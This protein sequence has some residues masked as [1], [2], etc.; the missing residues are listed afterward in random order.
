MKKEFVGVLVGAL[1]L[2]GCLLQTSD[3]PGGNEPPDDGITLVEGF[4]YESITDFENAWWI[5][6]SSDGATYQTELVDAGE[7]R[8]KALRFVFAHPES[9]QGNANVIWR[10]SVRLEQ[11][12]SFQFDIKLK[13]ALQTI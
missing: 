2:S 13:K 3:R 11:S 10:R 12:E 4:D 5:V 6:S 8:E 1:L 7:T 9:G